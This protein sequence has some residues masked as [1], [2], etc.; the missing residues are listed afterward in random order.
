MSY[1]KH[2]WVNNETLTAAKMNNI[3][4]GIEEAAQS[5]G[6]GDDNSIIVHDTDGTLDI[7]PTELIEALTQCKRVVMYSEIL[8]ESFILM[9]FNSVYENGTN[10]STYASYISFY[11]GG[12]HP[13]VL[14][15]KATGAD[16]PFVFD[17]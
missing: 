7:T 4:D 16:V 11:D 15:Y 13:E 12:A 14:P 5:G 6:G 17:D 10:Y 2:T 1:E 3:E 9:Q 8:G